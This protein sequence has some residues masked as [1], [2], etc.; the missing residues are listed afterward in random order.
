[1]MI[2]VS[3]QRKKMRRLVRVQVIGL[4]QVTTVICIQVFISMLFSRIR[5]V[6]I[7]ADRCLEKFV[8]S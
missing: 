5:E 7:S 8:P 6:H 3:A 2:E 4:M 1:M